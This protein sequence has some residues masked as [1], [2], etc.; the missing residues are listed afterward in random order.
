MKKTTIVKWATVLVLTGI[1]GVS[2]FHSAYSQDWVIKNTN[3]VDVENGGVQEN[4]D[5]EIRDG[6]I[7]DISKHRKKGSMPECP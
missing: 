6:I 5:V 3:L 4:V 1:M 2:G 7:F